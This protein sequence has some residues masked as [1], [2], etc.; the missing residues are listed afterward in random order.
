MRKRKK[1]LRR[2]QLRAWQAD[3]YSTIVQPL[4]N[5]KKR[6]KE[7]EKREL[8]EACRQIY[9]AVFGEEY[10]PTG[11]SDGKKQNHDGRGS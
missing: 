9:K 4:E 10:K 6:Q 2:D 7:R 5:E 11:G 3:K 1:D 8:D